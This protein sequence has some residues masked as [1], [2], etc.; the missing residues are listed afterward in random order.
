MAPTDSIEE[1]QDILHLRRRMK[2][3]MGSLEEALSTMDTFADRVFK[4]SSNVFAPPPEA[5]SARNV[6]GGH[7]LA[8]K[9]ALVTGGSRGIG[10]ATVR[11]LAHAGCDVVIAFKSSND[12]AA[13]LAQEVSESTGRKIVPLAADL[14]DASAIEALSLGIDEEF[15][16]RGVDVL[17]LNA[18][19]GARKPL[20]ELSIEEWDECFNVNLRSQFLLAKRFVPKMALRGF[21]RVVFVSSVSAFNGGVV[22]PH[23]AASK[24]GQLGLMHWLASTYSREGVTVNA[25]APS[26]ISGTSII[27][28][29]KE[30]IYA[31]R[32]PVGR[33]GTVDECAAAIVSI[34]SN[35]YIN[36]QTL[37]LDGGMYPR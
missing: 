34:A 29:E 18:S 28:P 32:V 3:L 13:T 11:Y 15:E 36:N 16:G 24:S 23:D 35:G 30:P 5:E 25:V 2:G 27:P 19:A 31:Q 12:S 22:G 9:L 21:G 17:I 1:E 6:S 4:A 26:L 14:S 33:M 8:G 10:A 7:P 37:S 20:E